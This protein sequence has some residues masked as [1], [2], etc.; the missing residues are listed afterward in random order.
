MPAETQFVNLLKSKWLLDKIEDSQQLN[1]AGTGTG[2][3]WT[4][5][6]QVLKSV[7]PRLSSHIMGFK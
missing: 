5:A 3:V 6:L 2:S 1:S 7:S 4:S